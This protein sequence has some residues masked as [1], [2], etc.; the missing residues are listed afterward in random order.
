MLERFCPSGK[1]DPRDMTGDQLTAFVLEMV[2]Q[3]SGFISSPKSAL[4]EI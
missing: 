1:F 4:V 3:E 2:S